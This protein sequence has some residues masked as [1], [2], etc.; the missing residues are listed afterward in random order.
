[1]SK[2]AAETQ[3]SSAA[4]KNRTRDKIH[5]EKLT[6]FDPEMGELED[7]SG[8]DSEEEIIEMGDTDDEGSNADPEEK[9][10]VDPAERQSLPQNP[11]QRQRREN[12][13]FDPS[14]Y[15][16][17]HEFSLDWPCLSFDIMRDDLG[18]ER[19]NYPQTVYMVA[20]TQAQRAK[21]N[22]VL[23]VKLSSL[24]KMDKEGDDDESDDEDDEMEERVI[25][26]RALTCPTTTNRIRMSPHS[27]T[28]ASMAE[29]GEVFIWDVAPHFASLNGAGTLTPQQN[30]PSSILRMHKHVEGYAIDWSPHP[31][32]T[33]GKI[34][35]GDNDG[36]IFISTRKE[37]GTWAT[38][39]DPLRSH[40]GSVEELQWSP[41]E[42][43]VFASASSDGTVKIWD[44]RAATRKHQ[45]SVDV[46][47]SD[48]NV[49]SW[50]STVP[51]LLAT[52]ADDGVWGV[53]DLR[54][55]ANAAKGKT[56]SAVASFTH[57]QSPITSVEFHPTE[58]S[59]VAVASADGAITTWD[60]SVEIDDEESRN[61]GGIE[62]PPQMMFD[63]RGLEDPK[64]V[65]WHKQ[66]PGLMIATGGGGINVF[67]TFNI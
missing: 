42:R 31:K 65:H 11:Q 57:H 59:I 12:M 22:K 5:D 26:E 66:V 29:T 48:V 16:M 27:H 10:D 64:E 8:E 61:T 60:L 50:C 38:G 30:K 14:T 7:M 21:D 2:R 9:M 20:G 49:A 24:S 25:E 58:D 3:T 19:R 28:A 43:H 40:T 54:S 33:M 47:S 35:T 13:E 41:T 34:A 39:K 45:L 37:D 4:L 17:L 53:W 56:V 46:S 36:N 6:E 23:V 1:M 32:E 44:A 62:V 55:F 18:E 67:K 51:H 15:D 52:G 63:H